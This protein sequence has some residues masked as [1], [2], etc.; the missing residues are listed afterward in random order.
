MNKKSLQLLLHIQKPTSSEASSSASS[1]SQGHKTDVSELDKSK[2]EGMNRLKQSIRNNKFLRA[3]ESGNVEIVKEMLRTQ[4][5]PYTTGKKKKQMPKESSASALSAEN[6]LMTTMLNL[7]VEDKR[8]GRTPLVHAAA[9]GYVHVVLELLQRNIDLEHCCDGSTPLYWAAS[10]G[11]VEVVHELLMY[12]ANPNAVNL[13]GWTAIM[14][15]SYFGHLE[16]VKCLLKYDDVFFFFYFFLFI[17]SEEEADVYTYGKN[18]TPLIYSVQNGHEKISQ[19]LLLYVADPFHKD[20]NG[21]CALDYAEEKSAQDCHHFALFMQQAGKLYSSL[22]QLVQPGYLYTYIHIYIYIYIYV[23][24][25]IYLTHKHIQKDA[26]RKVLRKY[27]ELH[28]RYP[29]VRQQL[30]SVSYMRELGN[31]EMEINEFCEVLCTQLNEYLLQMND[32]AKGGGDKSKT[33]DS[34]GAK[35]KE[36]EQ[37]LKAFEMDIENVQQNRNSLNTS[38]QEMHH[39]YQKNEE[40]YRE[41]AQRELEIELELEALKKQL[42]QTQTNKNKL[43]KEKDDIKIAMQ[44]LYNTLDHTEKELNGE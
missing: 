39:T 5:D 2:Q 3:C 29:R 15:A 16:I 11:H 38:L 18:G 8:N 42:E 9:N 12:G 35:T 26:M 33:T 30:K 43:K 27:K 14:N 7:E 34:N 22:C 31:A 28:H 36:K 23:Y 44:N 24:M 20:N 37:V 4:F 21:K 40:K 25:Y 10:R 19:M 17:N 41:L 6:R 32:S 1:S 13:K